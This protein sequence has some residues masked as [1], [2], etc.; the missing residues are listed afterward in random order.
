MQRLQDMGIWLPRVTLHAFLIARV[1]G[2]PL[3]RQVPSGTTGIS[4]RRREDVETHAKSLNSPPTRAGTRETASGIKLRL[5]G[6]VQFGES[7]DIPLHDHIDLRE[8]FAL[9]R[10]RHATVSAIE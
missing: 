2:A 6:R 8:L 3:K 9:D 4:Q 10:Q 5:A 1:R 7:D